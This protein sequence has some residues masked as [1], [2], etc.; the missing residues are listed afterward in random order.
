[1]PARMSA[2]QHLARLVLAPRWLAVVSWS[3]L[4]GPCLTLSREGCALRLWRLPVA[5]EA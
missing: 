2:H 4:L 5:G 3:P 1:M